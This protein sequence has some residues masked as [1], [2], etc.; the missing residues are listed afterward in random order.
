MARQ[1]GLSFGVIPLT[2]ADLSAWRL[3]LVV[4]FK[5]GQIGVIDTI[6][7]QGYV[8]ITYSGD[9]GVKSQITQE[10]LLE[11]V[12]LAVVLRRSHSVPDSR[13]DDYIKYHDRDWFK[14]IILRDWRPYAH[15]FIASFIVNVLALT[16]IL[17]TRQVYDRV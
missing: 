8:G 12:S 2:E 9:A 1:A 13:I 17:F 10:D 4:Q 14:K 16:G 11:N 15:I 5:D 6:D 7:Q 3:P